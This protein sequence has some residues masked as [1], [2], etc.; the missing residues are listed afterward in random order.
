MEDVK[1]TRIDH[2][3]LEY[4]RVYILCA[5]FGWCA[6]M[7]CCA[8]F[9]RACV[10]VCRFLMTPRSGPET[11]LEQLFQFVSGET[12]GLVLLVLDKVVTESIVVL[13]DDHSPD[14]ENVGSLED[15]GGALFVV[16]NVLLVQFL[17]A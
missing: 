2:S 17:V 15:G 16:F 14:H 13:V 11:D 6:Y 9:V 12:L 5:W 7:M 8:L 4:D 1:K 10:C 3:S